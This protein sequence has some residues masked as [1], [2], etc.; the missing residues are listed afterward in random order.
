M[1]LFRKFEVV[2][3]RR[4]RDRNAP[5]AWVFARHG[6]GR[7]ARY[8]SMD[9]RDHLLGLI[10]QLYASAGTTEGWHAFLDD[11]RVTLHGSA[12][13]LISH[14]RVSHTGN[15]MVT[16][17]ADPELAETYRQHWGALDPWAHSPKQ[18]QL[19]HRTVTVGDELIGHSEFKRTAFYADFARRY[20]A[21]RVIGTVVDAE[22]LSTSVLSINRSEPRPPFG[23]RDVELLEA[24]VPHVRRALQLHRRLT[25]ADIAS[26]DFASVINASHHA[27]FLIE[28]GGKISFMNRAA[29]DLTA[30]RDGLA[31]EHGELRGSRAADT[32]RLR[33]VIGSAITTSNGHGIGPG[34]TVVLG[35]PSGR[36]SLVV[37]VCP[38][39][40]QRPMFPGV[41]SASA[42]VFVTDPDQV[43]V[44]DEGMLGALFGLTSAEAKLTR[45][46]A[47]GVTLAK[48]ATRLGVRR[49]TVRS[50]VKAIFEKTNT[51][52]QADLIRL[53]L[54]GAPRM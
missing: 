13:N 46:L 33:S 44:P 37:L 5:F 2:G 15:V 9:P 3:R 17:L 32:T 40:R 43:D 52:R 19:R 28:K 8:R 41:E 36:R 12:A 31:V 54:N 50:R 21:V 23:E 49:E 22:V 26:E 38:L 39:S 47:Q 10:Q 48:A 11:L 42:V 18:S 20:D 7:S 16:T 35:R 34:G 24:L 27:V 25:A 45:L 4:R 53:V 1:P 14:S 51:H 6:E 29:S 30:I